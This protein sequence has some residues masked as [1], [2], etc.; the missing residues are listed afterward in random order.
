M[1]LQEVG[2]D[3]QVE[4]LRVEQFEREFLLLGGKDLGGGDRRLDRL[5]DVLLV[6]DK[7]GCVRRTMGD[8]HCAE[9]DGDAEEAADEDGC[10]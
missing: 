2:D 1:L 9:W 10:L 3:L 4:F 5:G 6:D 7:D 8:C